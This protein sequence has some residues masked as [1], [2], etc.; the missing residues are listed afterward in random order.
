VI[1]AR[2]GLRL[3]LAGPVPHALPHI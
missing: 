3:P 1:V 2:S